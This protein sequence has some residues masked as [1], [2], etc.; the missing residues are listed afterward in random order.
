[1][2]E[3]GQ[4]LGRQSP[5]GRTPALRPWLERTFLI[6]DSFPRGRSPLG[7]RLRRCMRS[8]K[9]GQ[10]SVYPR[11]SETY[12]IEDTVSTLYRKGILSVL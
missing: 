11:C 9:R 12:I 3:A 4:R 1:M 7:A 2:N 6:A 8:R 5:Q 10:P